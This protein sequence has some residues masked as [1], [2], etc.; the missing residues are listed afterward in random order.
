MMLTADDINMIFD[1]LQEK[2]GAGYAK[3]PKVGK[4]Q[5]K[6]SMMLEARTQME[7]IKNLGG[8]REPDTDGS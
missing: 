6:L 4:L 7:A 5:A 3:D 2:H 8:A 1:A